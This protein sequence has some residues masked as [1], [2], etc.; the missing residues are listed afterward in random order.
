MIHFTE[1]EFAPFYANYIT[2][3]L[4]HTNVVDGL[5]QL[6]EENIAFFQ[7][8][9]KDK[10]EYQYEVGKW[11]PKD[12][13]L[14]LIDAERIFCYRALRISRNDMTPLPGFEENDYVPFANANN[15]TIESLL[16]EYKAV[17]NA[18]ITLFDNLT[19]DQL[20]RV[21]IASNSTISVR[22]IGSIIIGHELHHKSVL[23]ERYL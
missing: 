11:T 14:H 8:I 2:K 12:I 9:P 23:E 1:N 21:G 17:R 19:E 20:M 13:L 5:K 4:Q 3:S 10:L 22:A 6:R 15:R 16:E 7:A 18:T